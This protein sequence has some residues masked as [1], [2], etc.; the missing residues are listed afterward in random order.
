[1]VKKLRKVKLRVIDG[2][3]F[4]CYG[5]YTIIYIKNDINLDNKG[6]FEKR[7]KCPTGA[8]KRSP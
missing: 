2:Y 1:M 8:V 3:I 5:C 7:G 6:S 4:P